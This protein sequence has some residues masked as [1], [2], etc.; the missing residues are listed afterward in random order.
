MV[1]IFQRGSRSKIKTSF[2]KKKEVFYLVFFIFIAVIETIKQ[3]ILFS[4]FFRR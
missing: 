4:D 3:N 2:H 1:T